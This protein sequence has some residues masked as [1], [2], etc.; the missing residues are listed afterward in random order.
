MRSEKLKDAYNEFWNRALN[1]ENEDLYSKMSLGDFVN[2]KKAI[3]NINNIVTLE[4]TKEFI[5][6]L[7]TTGIISAAQASKMMEDAESI[8]ANTNGFDIEYPLKRKDTETIVLTKDEIKIIAEVKCCIPAGTS[9]YGAA[10]EESI[11]KDIVG[12]ANGK[13]KSFIQKTEL[14]GYVKFLVLLGSNNEEEREKVVTSAHKIIAKT[15]DR[16]NG[17]KVI[18]FSATGELDTKTIYVVIINY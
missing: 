4:T 18:P 3:T 14:D 10:Q 1:T 16:Y 17:Y 5:R 9:A 7:E 8:N 15:S 2:L 6:Y 12:L 13:T 11:I